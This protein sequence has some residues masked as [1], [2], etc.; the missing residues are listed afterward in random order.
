MRRAAVLS[1]SARIAWGGGPMKTSPAAPQASAN[2]AFS[3]RKP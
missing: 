3:A 2:A 1:P